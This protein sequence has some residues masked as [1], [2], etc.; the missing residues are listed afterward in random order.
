M[1]MNAAGRF[2]A[3]SRARDLGAAARALAPGVVM[4][5]P[6]TDAPVVGSEAVA[7]ALQAVEAACDEFRRTR[8]LVGAS[9]FGRAA[10]R[11]CVRGARQ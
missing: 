2:I 7:A 5:N 3:V 9:S 11:A 1:R 4:R 6:A 8:L 10:V